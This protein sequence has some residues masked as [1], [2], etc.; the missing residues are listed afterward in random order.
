M[1]ECLEAWEAR[2]MAEQI[3]HSAEHDFLTGLPN[4]LLLSD[5]VGQA[6]ALAQ[7]N[8]R[9]CLAALFPQGTW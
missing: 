7:R 8:L 9:T 5:R 2:A 4:L 1:A 6:V 3:A